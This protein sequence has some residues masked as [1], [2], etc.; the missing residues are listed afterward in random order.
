MGG[1]GTDVGRGVAVDPAGNAVIAGRFARTAHFSDGLVEDSVVCTA[2]Q[3]DADVFLAKYGPAGEL[4]WVESFGGPEANMPRGVTTDR[5]GNIF[6]AGR[7]KGTIDLDPGPGTAS[8]TTV[9]VY[10][11]F[12]SKFDPQG[13][14]TWGLTAGSSYHT[15]GLNVM[16]DAVGSVLL[17]GWITESLDMDPGPDS[18]ILVSHG[19]MDA[20]LAK[21]SDA[22]LNDLQYTVH[23]DNA[24][25]TTGWQLLDAGGQPLFSGA[26]TPVDAGQTL[27]RTWQVPSGCYR[28]AV[29]DADGNGLASAGYSLAGN[30]QPLVLASGDFEALSTVS[31]GEGSCV[32]LGS[33]GLEAAS[34]AQGS[35][36][37]DD[38][39]ALVPVDNATAYTLWFF[40]PHGSF[41]GTA[42]ASG[43]FFPVEDLPWNTPPDLPLNV[44]V[45]AWVDGQALPYGPACA[46]LFQGISG[47]R[48]E[49]AGTARVQLSPNPTSDGRTELVV[50]GLPNGTWPVLVHDATGR[51][52]VRLQLTVHEGTARQFLDLAPLADGFY[53]ITV[54]SPKGSWTGR[55]IVSR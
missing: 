7:F 19:S 34:C 45:R 26:G 5:D 25:A 11:L 52:V 28:I 31:A 44:R 1:D 15:R 2:Q 18:L 37:P 50:N 46:V 35:F 42:D 8:H 36:T 47:I 3:Q 13:N 54:T 20:Y 33:A 27:E 21:Y 40:D 4:L 10:D 41:S 24:P 12:L 23:L 51:A 6:L 43:T 16:T 29:S 38:T 14:F 32:P 22:E 55:L 17:T 49:A 9:G 53:G 30:G 39:L 48:E